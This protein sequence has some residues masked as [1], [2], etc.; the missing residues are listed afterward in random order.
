MKLKL[1][2]EQ[3]AASRKFPDALIH[4][5]AVLLF[6]FAPHHGWFDKERIWIN[7][8]YVICK[9][10]V[11]CT[12]NIWFLPHM[13][14]LLHGWLNLLVTFAFYRSCLSAWLEEKQ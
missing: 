8:E 12:C 10:M 11:E 3:V 13:K 7:S 5:G 6:L 14:N 1:N 2:V 9:W 4:H